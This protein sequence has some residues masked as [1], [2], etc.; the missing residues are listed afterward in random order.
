MNI[1]FLDISEANKKILIMVAGVVIAL[2]FDIFFIFFPLVGK[3]Y[4]LKAKIISSSKDLSYLKQQ[5]S[6]LDNIKKRLENLKTE[7]VKYGKGFPKEEEIPALLGNIS[8]IAG[9]LGIEI[10]AVKPVR[11]AFQEEAKSVGELFREVLVEIYAKGG[12]HQMGQFINK[13][14]TLDK[15]MEIRD[16]EITADK[17]SPRRHFF[18]L[19]VATYILMG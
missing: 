3:S 2:I 13:L 9:K 12:Y 4:K 11:M 18:R 17:N 14:E 16:I 7:Q 5:I 6:S 8:T 15:F 1:G 19:L 10:I